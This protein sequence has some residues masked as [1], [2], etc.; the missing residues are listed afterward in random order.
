ML[1]SLVVNRPP[2]AWPA[3]R[4]AWNICSSVS[5]LLW[6]DKRGP[7]SERDKP[8]LALTMPDRGIAPHPPWRWGNGI[9]AY[10]VSSSWGA[11]CTLGWLT[12][13]L[14]ADWSLAFWCGKRAWKIAGNAITGEFIFMEFKGLCDRGQWSWHTAF[15][16]TG[17]ISHPIGLPQPRHSAPRGKGCLIPL[18]LGGPLGLVL[19]NTVQQ[20]W[21]CVS[22]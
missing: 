8:C 21:Q 6:L 20:R 18:K 9:H 10:K 1:I 12:L 19:M 13:T 11:H 17:C 7:V 16:N 4:E 5:R 2:S 15:S 3:K 14:T 22:S